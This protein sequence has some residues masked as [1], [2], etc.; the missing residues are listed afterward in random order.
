MV[1]ESDGLRRTAEENI[2]R[3]PIYVQAG[4]LVM[5]AVGPYRGATAVVPKEMA[6][7]LV[8]RN[9]IVIRPKSAVVL[10]DYLAAALNSEFVSRQ[11]VQWSSGSVIEALTVNSMQNI[12]V[13]VPEME[14]QR[15]IVAKV[16]EARDRWLSARRRVAEEERDFNELVRKLAD[17]GGGR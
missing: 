7:M 6:D 16:F 15:E 4:D 12:V 17:D 13:P 5:N 3:T 11:I 9:V 10:G 8:S 14:T 2:Q 1:L